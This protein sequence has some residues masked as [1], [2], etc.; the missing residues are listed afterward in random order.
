MSDVVTSNTVRLLPLGGLGEVGMN[1]L[2]L[3]QRGEVILVDCGV[4]FDDRGLGVDVVHPDFSAL[5]TFGRILKG[6]VITHGHEDH[7]GALPYLLRRHDVPVWA[8]PYALGL[9]RERLGEHEVLAH[10]RLHETRPRERFMVGSFGIEPVRVTHSIADATALAITTDAGTIVHTGDFKVDE[11]PPD[12][13][14]FDAPRLTELGDAG[15]A[16]LMSDSTNIDVEG[17]TGS[18]A[19]VG[20]ALERLVR[21]ATGAVIVTMFASN[22]HRL[23]LLGDIARSTGRKIV[24][25]GRGVGTHARVARATGYLPWPDDLVLPEQLA[26]ERPRSQILAIATGSQG[27][28]R[29]A[30][31]RLARN[32]H[33]GYDVQPGDTVILSARTIPGNEP[34]V[35]AIMGQLLRKGVAVVTR[36]TDRAIHVSGH[37]H[38]PDQRRM[39]ELVRPRSF[40]PVHGTIHHLTRHAELA[41][42]MGVPSIAVTE[43]GRVVEVSEDRV[44]LGETVGAGRVHVWGGRPVPQS[45][46]RE[47][48]ALAHE[49]AAFCF[50][51]LDARG[52]TQSVFVT[53]RG[54]MDDDDAKKDLA[55]AEDAVRRAILDAPQH[56]TEEALSEYVRLAVRRTFKERRGKKPV[57]TARVQKA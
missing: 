52:I 35:N 6:V 2:A 23:R 45:V 44:L 31:A 41:R 40:V 51:L 8:P 27:E 28:E 47:R 20:V 48:A 50:V 22:V 11:A 39:I 24:L 42:E 49:G 29:A 13:E 15:V 57:T 3:E 5:D 54:V 18:E 56:A 19:G 16:L 1:C 34:E 17:P 36:Q 30:L 55:A 12:G 38:R 10:A 9:I 14:H 37:A 43:N 32:D 46:I 21:E 33:P 25:L 26:R 53:T 7:I 4:T